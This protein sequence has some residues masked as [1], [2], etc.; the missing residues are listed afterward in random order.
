MNNWKE[1]AI[2]DM[3][4]ELEELSEKGK[5]ELEIQS[6][7]AENEGKCVGPRSVYVNFC[8]TTTIPEGFEVEEGNNK[9]FVVWKNRLKCVK[10]FQK[11]NVACGNNTCG[12]VDACVL[13]IVG[14]I[15]LI[16]SAKVKGD[17]G[18]FAYASC[19]CCLNVDECVKCWPISSCGDPQWGPKPPCSPEKDVKIE[20]KDDK[21]KVSVNECDSNCNCQ[22]VTISGTLKLS[23][24][25]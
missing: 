24:K 15:P 22:N 11:V 20:L 21:V 3:F 7:E 17:T 5:E 23:C 18:T 13:K 2:D 12:Q 9:G 8:C 6:Q 25:R 19:C 10:V 4:D 1:I 14:C 16:A